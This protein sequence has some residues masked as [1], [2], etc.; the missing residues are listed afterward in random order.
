[1]LDIIGIECSICG[2]PIEIL[3]IVDGAA[4]TKCD[5]C[6]IV[7]KPI[8]KNP[9]TCPPPCNVDEKFVHRPP[10]RRISREVVVEHRRS[11]KN[12]SKTGTDAG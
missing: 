7:A 8:A 1:M 9:S 5:N 6:S 3:A 12:W 10:R 11:I 4:H 2:N